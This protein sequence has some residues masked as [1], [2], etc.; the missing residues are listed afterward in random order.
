[1]ELSPDFKEWLRLLNE[2]RVEYLVVGAYALAFHG[3][4]RFT[5]DLDILVRPDPENAGKILKALED[6][7]MGSLNLTVEDFSRPHQVIQ[8]GYPPVRIDLLTSLTGLTWEQIERGK[9]A[10]E[11]GS[12][13]V[14]FI[15][16]TELIVNKRTLGRHKDLADI[17]TLES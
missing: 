10:G 12:V 17:E 9:T 6:F 3:A 5:G 2:K 14:Y 16:K 1:M 11:L 4:P 8:M 7:G 13:P 15:G